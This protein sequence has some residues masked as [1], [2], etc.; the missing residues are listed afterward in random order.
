MNEVA[1][2]KGLLDCFGTPW[3]DGRRRAPEGCAPKAV[4]FKHPDGVRIELNS[5][6]CGCLL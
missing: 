2:A 4:S 1:R 5:T 3:R 6:D